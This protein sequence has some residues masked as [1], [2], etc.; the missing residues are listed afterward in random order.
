MSRTTI[1]LQ[2]YPGKAA[3]IDS[4]VDDTQ[5][6]LAMN[7]LYGPPR[8]PDYMTDAEWQ[9]WRELEWTPEE[10]AKL[11]GFMRERGVVL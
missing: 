5:V 9:T 4:E 8:K 1:T 7:W 11:R 2:N 10:I 3:G 6:E